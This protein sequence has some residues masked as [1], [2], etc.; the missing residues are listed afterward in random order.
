MMKYVDTNITAKKGINYVRN[1]IEG[2]GS[3]F[4]KIEQEN[5]LGI[6]AIIEFI[7]HESPMNKSIAIQIKSGNS[8]YKCKSAECV[9]QIGSHREYW[10]NYSLPVFGIIY[11]PDHNM[12][13]WVNVK[14]K[15]KESPEIN[16]IRFK[17][18]RVNSLDINTFNSLFK[19]LNT[20]LKPYLEINE[21]IDFFNSDI[22]EESHVG[23]VILFRNYVN[24]ISVWNEF[25]KALKR[26]ESHEI[27]SILIYYIAHIPWHGDISYHGE[28]ISNKIKIHVSSIISN[29]D[30]KMVVKLL[31][32][33]D[34][35]DGICR[36]TIGQ[37]IEAIISQ[38]KE[39]EYKLEVIITDN[40]Y[41]KEL[42]INAA[43]IFSYYVGEKARPIL[44]K[45]TIADNDII[46]LLCAEIKEHGGI[47]LYS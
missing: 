30:K 34:P 4:H 47:N 14:S 26:K 2:S 12:A 27:P 22:N 31:N 41:S 6:D 5:D 8:Y 36:G 33:I 29:F 15:L 44:E 39:I 18:N 25:L 16:E 7:H 17:I 28:N 45:S 11:V 24:E 40:N 23:M 38:I 13:Y 1:L 20:N 32:I 35:D 43:L 3:L 9:I 46:K 10:L 42:R 19:P 21:A 37:S